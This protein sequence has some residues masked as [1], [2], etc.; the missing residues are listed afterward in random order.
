MG[1]PYEVMSACAPSLG[2]HAGMTPTELVDAM[3]PPLGYPVARWRAPRTSRPPPGAEEQEQGRYGALVSALRKGGCELL[4][5]TLDRGAGC[6]ARASNRTGH[7]LLHC[8]CRLGDEAA[9]KMLLRRGADPAVSDDCGKTALHDACWA[10]NLN[11]GILR[12]LI[13]RDPNLLFATDR[14][15]ATA[16]DYC[17]TSLRLD[18]VRFFARQQTTWWPP[19]GGKK[20]CLRAQK[21]RPESSPAQ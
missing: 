18:F 8:A 15:R 3:L 5:K 12:A 2:L 10:V 21:P 14:F 1:L 9:V 20:A 19:R 13:D 16:L 11:E 6:D 7:T 17:H 4:R